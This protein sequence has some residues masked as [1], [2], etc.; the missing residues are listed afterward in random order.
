[1]LSISSSV[2]MFH[3]RRKSVAEKREN[4]GGKAWKKHWATKL[5]KGESHGEPHPTEKKRH[6]RNDNSK[7]KTVICRVGSEQ[8]PCP[9]LRCPWWDRKKIRY[10]KLRVACPLGIHNG[11]KYPRQI[12][13]IDL[14]LC[15]VGRFACQVPDLSATRTAIPERFFGRKITVGNFMS[16][17][18]EAWT[19]RYSPSELPFPKGLGK[20][21]RSLWRNFIE[22]YGIRY[23]G[24]IE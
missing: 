11:A 8:S 2:I 12:F 17:K 19:C 18:P 5:E 23:D 9:H 14:V 15:V 4:Q 24:S 21:E 20:G 3:R 22:E 13:F 1:M 10:G 7:G 6:G 16:R